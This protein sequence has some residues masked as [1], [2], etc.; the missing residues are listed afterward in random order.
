MLS[1]AANCFLIGVPSMGLGFFCGSGLGYSGDLGKRQDL[2]LGVI[3]DF[4]PDSCQFSSEMIVPKYWLD[5]PL[6]H[7]HRVIAVE[8][9]LTQLQSALYFSGYFF[10]DIFMPITLHKPARNCARGDVNCLGELI[11]TVV[12][13]FADDRRYFRLSLLINS[14]VVSILTIIT[15]R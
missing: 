9:I 14:H 7:G 3:W 8:R 5:S 13:F 12:E 10:A 2:T 15:G 11:L 6:W 4:L 1:K